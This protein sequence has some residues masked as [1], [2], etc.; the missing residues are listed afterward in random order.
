MPQL[1]IIAQQLRSI[2]Y[3]EPQGAIVRNYDFAIEANR[4]GIAEIV[5]FADPRVFDISTS[6]IAVRA[7]TAS[8]GKTAALREM[9]Y[10]GVPIAMFATPKV[11]EVWS[12]VADGSE[13]MPSIQETITYQ[14]VGNFFKRHE[15]ELSPRSLVSAK[16]GV[17]QLSF[18]EID[19]SLEQFARE[20][21]KKGLVS[22][23]EYAI[24]L[25]GETLAL[26]KIEDGQKPD[27]LIKLAISILGARILQDK[28]SDDDE[29]RT[30]DVFT[31]L[32][33]LQSKFPNYFT[34]IAKQ[35]RTIGDDVV[36]A[37]YTGLSGDFTFRSL[38]NDMLG[39]FY[40]NTLVTPEMRRSS[41][42]Y[43]TPR[44]IAERILKRLPVEDLAPEERVVFDG[45][46]GSGSLLLASY[47][48]L[49]SLLPIQWSAERRYEYLLRSIQGVDIDAFACDVARLSL[50]LYNLPMGDS[51]QVKRSDVF[52]AQPKELFGRTP[53][54]IVGNPPFQEPRSVDGKRIQLAARVL[55][56]YLN[57][58]EE[59]GFVGVVLPL[60]F[61]HN[62]SPLTMQMR[63][64][65]LRQFDILEIWHLPETAV[66]DS[67]V[68]TAVILAKK[69]PANHRFRSGLLT[70]VEHAHSVD[71]VR[72]DD[73]QSF[74]ASYVFPQDSWRGNS[75]YRLDSSLFESIW[76]RIESRFRP[77]HKEYC[78]LRNGVQIGTKA[79]LDHLSE[80][81]Q[82]VEWRR[83]LYNNDDSTVLRPYE[84]HW[85]KQEIKY[86]KYP[87]KELHR[88]RKPAH[89]E[90]SPKLIINATRNPGNPWRF[91]C[92][93]DTNRL[94]V[95]ENFH[96]GLPQSST[97]ASALV[98]VLNSKVANAWFAS[99]NYQRDVNLAQLKK[100][101]FPEFT[102]EQLDV[103][104]KLV[105]SI[106][107]IENSQSSPSLLDEIDN[108]VF[109]AYGL[110]LAEQRQINA[111][112]DAYPRP[113]QA[114]VRKRS[115]KFANNVYQG[116]T[117]KVTATVQEVDYSS[118]SLT[119]VVNSS[120]VKHTIA[121]PENLPGWALRVGATFN[122]VIPWNQRY[123]QTY[124]DVQW[125]GFE[126][127]GYGYLSDD[128]LIRLIERYAE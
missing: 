83:F 46:C 52:R 36:D 57:W 41:G 103:L 21:T 76:T 70:R 108:I 88:Q 101:P 16:R 79:L 95:T 105:S 32:G 28:L 35:A 118:M 47:D 125:L 56:H 37:L 80:N 120:S 92:A 115:A 4:K 67:A 106:T 63:E 82:G 27:V 86:L 20:A 51:W 107:R 39:Y 73:T 102:D 98:A 9:S 31:L 26:N 48:R 24:G 45:T 33:A 72:V 81:N 19:P 93:I 113:G 59:G 60:T 53:K 68:A 42:I 14:E 12:V 43:Y 126:P 87:S 61:L 116:E 18:F 5:A 84:I 49:S 89:F 124:Q 25:A 3:S 50:M 55:E 85:D 66:S 13:N 62:T 109:N 100:L 111:W 69:L 127:L 119:F 96:Y 2:G 1:D 123:S 11:V 64:L 94:V 90:V 71:S 75:Q 8:G 23:F 99:H 110:T 77:I 128:E 22:Q 34:D 65:L 7:W 121:V 44:H 112:L 17:R 58:V 91:Y 54:I 40:E 104:D 97:T 10:L 74:D 114:G 38:T 6:C 122:A 30:R 117:W 29:L 15:A 78:E